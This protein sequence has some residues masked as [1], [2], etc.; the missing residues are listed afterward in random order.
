MIN[1]PCHPGNG[2]CD[3]A[4][5][6]YAYRQQQI[7]NFINYLALTDNPNDFNNQSTAALAANL[8]TGSLTSEEIQY[9]ESEVAKR[10]AM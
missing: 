1:S 6:A 8:N 3:V 10:W 2:V 4:F 7:E 5:S 9:I